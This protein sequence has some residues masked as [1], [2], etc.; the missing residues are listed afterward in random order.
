MVITEPDHL[1]TVQAACK[2]VPG[3]EIQIFVLDNKAK[4]ALTDCRANE[5]LANGCNGHVAAPEEILSVAAL[6]TH[7]SSD[8]IRITDEKT[9]R[10]TT[11]CMFP[12]SGT[13]GLPK[14]CRLS[15][16]AEIA[17]NISIQSEGKDYDVK[18]L[19]SIPL[20]HI[21]GAALIHVNP[22]R[23]GEPVYI[24]AR[25]DL[26]KYASTIQKYGIT[27]TATTPQMVVYLLKSGLP[28]KDM[29]STLRYVWCG[30]A[31]I[32]TAVLSRFY[33]ML[34]SN[35]IITG[36]WG[37]SETGAQ[38]C[39]KWPERDTTGSV[40]RLTPGTEIR[41]VLAN[42]RLNQTLKVEIR[43]DSLFDVQTH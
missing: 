27:D 36:T 9:A 32:D 17:K 19:V 14:L 22:I 35:A 26:K 31:P 8:W 16:Y 15:H 2:G 12:T 38:T 5:S 39:F 34:P 11:A 28:L 4:G 30:S 37:M 40:G 1:E 41:Y 7:G 25:F 18:S 33:E 10:E 43:A 21:F 6:L 24:M 42:F 3:S 13:T 29:L 23:R 20:F